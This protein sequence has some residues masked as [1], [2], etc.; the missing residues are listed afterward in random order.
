MQ[1]NPHTLF[2]ML[3]S[4]LFVSDWKSGMMQDAWEEFEGSL[5]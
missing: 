3:S 5:T 4:D 1:Q 2:I